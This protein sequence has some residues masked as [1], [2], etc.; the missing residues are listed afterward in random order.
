MLLAVDLGEE[1]KEELEIDPAVNCDDEKFFPVIEKFAEEIY[2]SR[3]KVGPNGDV[4]QIS[5]YAGD[6]S[7]YWRVD[8]IGSV[9]I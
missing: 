4:M 3:G 9:V 7:K 5:S 1:F 6:Y 2:V 8:F